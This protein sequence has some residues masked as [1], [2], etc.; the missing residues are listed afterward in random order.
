LRNALLLPKEDVCEVNLLV[1][2]CREE[3]SHSSAHRFRPGDAELFPVG[4]KRFTESNLV[5]SGAD[6]F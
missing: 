4:V 6:S 2:F 1:R 5:N 3:C